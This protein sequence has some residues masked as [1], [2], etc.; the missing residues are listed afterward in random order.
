[1]LHFVILARKEILLLTLEVAPLMV[2]LDFQYFSASVFLKL[3]SDILNDVI[4]WMNGRNYNNQLNLAKNLFNF[5]FSTVPAD[6]LA[7]NIF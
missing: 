3:L 4:W 6:S 1:M 2:W 5:V 7:S